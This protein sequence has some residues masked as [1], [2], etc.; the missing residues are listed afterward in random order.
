MR[1]S[2]VHLIDSLFNTSTFTQRENGFP[3]AAPTSEVSFSYLVNQLGNDSETWL[4]DLAGI[5]FDPLQDPGLD[6]SSDELSPSAREKIKLQQ[7]ARLLSDWL[8]SVVEP[9]VSSLTENAQSPLEVAFA[10]LSGGQ[11]ARAAVAAADGKNL[12]LATLI[13]LLGTDDLTI[14]QAAQAQI[15]DW[16]NTGSLDMVP[17]EVRKTHE[18]LTGNTT[19]SAGGTQSP[20]Y[21]CE[22]L[23]WLQAFG[24][25]LWYGS[26]VNEDLSI[27]VKD[28][29]ES[30]TNL[31]LKVPSP[32]NGNHLAV[33]FELLRL[34]GSIAPVP[35]RALDAAHDPWTAW[36]LYHVLFRSLKLFK[37][38]NNLGD[39][40]TVELACELEQGGY[41]GQSMFVLCH[42]EDDALAKRH[43]QE[44]LGRNVDVLTGD[45]G[46]RIKR[47]GL[48]DTVIYES[49]A[50]EYRYQGNHLSECKALISAGAFNEAHTVLTTFVAPEA[51]IANRI[52]DIFSLLMMFK[53]PEKT[54][55]TWSKGGK[56]YLDYVR[57][58]EKM[59][60]DIAALDDS[61]LPPMTARAIAKNLVTGLREMPAD[62]ERFEVRVAVS[63]MKTYVGRLL[64]SVGLD[65]GNERIMGAG[66]S[67]LIED[68]REMSVGYFA[69]QCAA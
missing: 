7:R 14:R 50:L 65:V 35:G 41:V 69:A 51:V 8:K 12:H 59:S 66:S 62:A 21:L 10:H 54:V 42:L 32:A 28:Y 9:D 56:V 64:K 61:S 48:S 49:Q 40:L 37:D 17:K 58:V 15:N 67:E 60:P 19:I 53:N 13:T 5:L 2:A 30:F 16:T 24:L 33:E 63:L 36:A 43:L 46:S 3:K 47:M 26:T 20:V 31:K 25:R 39:K 34:Y 57:F 4:W 68:V 18:L 22:N 52:S 27:A 29:E 45:V 11:I 38:S 44:L 1:K 23:T 6:T 55:S